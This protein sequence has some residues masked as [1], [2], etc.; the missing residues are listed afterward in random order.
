MTVQAKKVTNRTALL[1]HCSRQEAEQIRH[2]ARKER[3]TISGFILNAVL[4]KFE[5]EERLEGRRQNYREAAA[6]ATR[7]AVSNK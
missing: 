5:F 3:R 1:I 7:V 4:S 6:E 2:A